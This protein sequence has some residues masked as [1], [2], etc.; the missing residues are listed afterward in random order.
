MDDGLGV[1]AAILA[2]G[3]WPSLFLEMNEWRVIFVASVDESV[4]IK[5][6]KKV[7]ESATIIES[8]SPAP[9]KRRQFGCIFAVV[10]SLVSGGYLLDGRDLTGRKPP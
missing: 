2:V 5:R 7:S 4:V 3:Q 1:V 6:R 10:T 8:D 9:A